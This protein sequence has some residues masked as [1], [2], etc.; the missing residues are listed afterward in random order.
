[1]SPWERKQLAA[2][3]FWGAFFLYMSSMPPGL[4]PY[5]DAGEFVVA[6]HTAGVAHPPSYPLYVLLGRAADAIPRG[7]TGSVRVVWKS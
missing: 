6:A 1:M 2:A 4:A 3:V 5:R 7:T